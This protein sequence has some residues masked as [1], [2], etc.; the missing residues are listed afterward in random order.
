MLNHDMGHGGVYSDQ[1]GVSGVSLF[2]Q[3]PDRV[4]PSLV[5]LEASKYRNDFGRYV[6]AKLALDDCFFEFSFAVPNNEGCPCWTNAARSYGR[7]L[8]DLVERRAEIDQGVECDIAPVQ[9]DGFCELDFVDRVKSIGIVLHETT[10]R[11]TIEET[12]YL[13][14]K[15]GNVRVRSLMGLRSGLKNG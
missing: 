8:S 7:R 6:A 3:S 12:P 5:T 15:L 4:I 11:T 10:V 9:W 13:S 2:V 14:V 1:A